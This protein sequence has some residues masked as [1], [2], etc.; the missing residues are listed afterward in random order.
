MNNTADHRPPHRY[1]NQSIYFL[2]SRVYQN[3]DLLAGDLRKKIFLE[4]LKNLV[5]QY[6]IKLYAWS[7]LDNHYHLL[8]Y[9]PRGTQLKLFLNRLHSIVALKLN[10]QDGVSGRRVWYQYFDHSIRDEADFWK[11]FNYIHQNP[12]KH[13]LRANLA[14]ILIIPFQARKVGVK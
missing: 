5:N 12:I 14:G 13:G 6:N 8:F 9:L 3:K 7:I 11:H 10:Q 4:V 2:T 1:D